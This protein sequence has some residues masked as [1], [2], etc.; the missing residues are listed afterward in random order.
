MK[1]INKHQVGGVVYTPFF[2]NELLAQRAAQS[3]KSSKTKDDKDDLEKEIIDVIKESGLPSDV[4]AFTT[5]AARFLRKSQSFGFIGSSGSQYTM[6]QLMKLHSMANKVKFNSKMHEKALGQIMDEGAGSEVALTNDG[7]IYVMD[8]DKNIK[9]ISVQNYHENRDKYQL[10]T[11]SQLMHLREQDSDLAWNSA[12]LKDMSGVI[13]MKTITSHIKDTIKSFGK[14]SASEQFDRY[15]IKNKGKIEEGFEQLLGMSPDGVYN[16]TTKMKEGHQGYNDADSLM[17][18]VHYLYKTLP[19]NMK[20][21]LRATAAAE[22]LDPNK[23][24]NVYQ[25]L[26]MA[27]SEHT[28]HE[29]ERSTDVKMDSAATKQEMGEGKAGKTIEMSGLESIAMGSGTTPVLT[30]IASSNSRGGI[31]TFAQPYPLQD[32]QGDIVGQGD[33]QSVLERSTIG[34]IVDKNSI[35]F[36]DHRISDIE[37]NK[38][39]YDGTSTLNRAYLPIDM[40]VYA[41]TGQIKPD[42][43][44]QKRYDEF[45]QWL[46]Q[47]YGFTQGAIDVKLHQ[48]GLDLEFDPNAK[49]WKFK[50]GAYRPFLILNGYAS[51]KAVDFDDNSD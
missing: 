29:S 4:D 28:S 15:T 38:I 17:Q 21:V 49:V 47:G 35:Y 36:G 33:L 44:A 25:L 23:T 18:A 48:L 16:I 43:N 11:N 12:I 42:L 46:D 13:G 19:T 41:Q 20:H 31:Q 50:E 2:G 10:L 39:V 51:T 27:I 9:A 40:N 37:L 30:T 14:T 7:G 3:T 22:G 32:R 34:N 6:N 24:E 45:I 1:I 5:T 26:A 8:E